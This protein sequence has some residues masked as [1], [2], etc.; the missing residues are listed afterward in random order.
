VSSVCVAHVNHANHALTYGESGA[1][2]RGSG[3]RR[4]KRG[5]GP[6]LP[7]FAYIY[8]SSAQNGE[9]GQDRLSSRIYIV[10]CIVCLCVAALRQRK[11]QQHS[12]NSNT[13]ATATQLQQQHS[14]NNSTAATAT[15]LQ[16]QHSCNSLSLRCIGCGCCSCVAH[17]EGH[18]AGLAR[19]CLLRGRACG[20]G[21]VGILP[22]ISEYR[23]LSRPYAP[24]E[25]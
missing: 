12:C 24:A 22:L 1:N 6:R 8:R 13:A 17:G 23:L 20:R 3:G 11:W 9:G 21:Q 5:R 16:Q 4:A 18:S 7:V 2:G 19:A 15:Q 10:Y 14:C 25:S